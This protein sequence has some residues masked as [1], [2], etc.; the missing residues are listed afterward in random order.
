[1]GQRLAVNLD[2]AEANLTRI[3]PQEL[4]SAVLAHGTAAAAGNGSPANDPASREEAER[5]QTIWWYLLA[6]AGVLFAT[7]TLMSNR[8]SRRSS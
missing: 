7:E 6:L 2:P 3:D 4:K 5:R 1:M 8:L